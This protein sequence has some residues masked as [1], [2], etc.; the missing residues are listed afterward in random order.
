MQFQ[1]E[2]LRDFHQTKKMIWKLWCKA[3]GEKASKKNCEADKIAI[4]RT[5]IFITY[6]IT[7]LFICA[8]VWKHWNDKQLIEI[9]INGTKHDAL[10]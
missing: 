4:I 2:R 8:G 9:Y 1:K 10:L 3:L 7:N 5:F 6:L